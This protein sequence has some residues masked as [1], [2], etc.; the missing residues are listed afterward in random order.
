MQIMK[1]ICHRTP[2]DNIINLLGICTEP[3]GKPLYVIVEYAR[4]GN[5]K[6]FLVS[7][8]PTNFDS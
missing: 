3:K 6:D 1:M 7:V 5:L 8:S 2:Y 4:Y